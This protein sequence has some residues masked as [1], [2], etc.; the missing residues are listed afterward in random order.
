MKFN[1]GAITVLET[2]D[3]NCH[4]F[5]QV[6]SVYIP[7]PNMSGESDRVQLS[8]IAPNP[9]INPTPQTP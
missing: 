5:L 7:T 2:V 8:T 3:K 6:K 1:F 9:G 4:I